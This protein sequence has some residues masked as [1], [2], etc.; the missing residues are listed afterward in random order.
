MTFLNPLLL[1]GLVAAAIPLI[2]HLFNFRR[3]KRVDFSSLAFLKELQQTTMQRV[4]IKQWLLLALRTLAIASLVLA[5]ARPTLTG[6]LAGTVGGRAATA[7]VI[8]L[9]NS[10]SMAL[11]DE[12]GSYLDQARALAAGIIEQMAPGDEVTLLM[13]AESSPADPV[14]YQHP[15]PALDALAGVEVHPGAATLAHT[16]DRAA[17]LLAGA[18]Q[19]NREIYLLS[20]LQRTTLGDSAGTEV[21]DG[22]VTR[23]AE[24]RVALLPVGTRAYPNVAVTEVRVVS[25]IVE[26]GQPVRLEATL[27]NYGTSRLEDYVA[28]V[29]LEGERVAQAAVDLEPGAATDVAFTVTPQQRGW[30]AGLVQIEDDAFEYDNARH[31]TLHVPARRRLLLVRGEEQRT[32]YIELALSPELAPGRL[33]FQTEVIPESALAATGLGVYDAVILVGPRTLSSGEVAA[34]VRYVEAG[35]GLMIFPGASARAEDYNALLAGLGGGRFTGFSGELGPGRPVATFDRVD[36]EHPLFEGVFE[37]AALRRE[38]RVESPEFYFVMDYVPGS[39]TEQ[40]LIRLSSGVPFLQE[41]RH[42]R[43]AAFLLGVAPDPR[44]SDLPVRGLFIPLLYRSMYYLS[45]GETTG[46]GQLTVGRPGT[47]RLA[48]APEDVALRLVGPDGQEFTPEQRNLFGAVLLQLD[49]TVRQPGI[50][51]IRAGEALVRRVAFNLDPRESDLQRL[52]PGE[53]AARLSE[54]TGT[55]VQVLAVPGGR[56]AVAEA[57]V[58]GRTGVELWNVFLLLALVF[59]VAEMFVARQWRPESVPA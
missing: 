41:L 49:A 4:R 29:F 39:A 50:Y 9:D 31:F 45:A 38:R 21:P 5:F 26:A 32:D 37:P 28:S 54:H 17:R 57:L 16:L 51:D 55:R 56:E 22:R 33:A 42:G 13:T 14:A 25:R 59:L 8:V 1:I 58:A 15:G 2:I 27:V 48:G 34:L 23:P 36:L 46:A 43:G 6:D 3:P 24:I 44:W 11:R 53:A 10:L 35:G 18:P 7:Q 40:T 12:Q 47:L 30:L 52:P 20:D 19:L